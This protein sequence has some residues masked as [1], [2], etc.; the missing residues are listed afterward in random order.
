M[1][2]ELC[3]SSSDNPYKRNILNIEYDRVLQGLQAAKDNAVA[4]RSVQSEQ[5][6]LK[7]NRDQAISLS[8]TCTNSTAD[9]PLAW[10]GAHGMVV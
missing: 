6:H 10:N 9:F 4:M 2:F 5:I 8:V 1:A 3:A 7:T